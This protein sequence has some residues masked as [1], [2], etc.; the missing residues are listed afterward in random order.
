MTHYAIYRLDG[1]TPER[2]FTKVLVCPG[3]D[4]WEEALKTIRTFEQMRPGHVFVLESQ[5]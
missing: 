3:F 4:C 5:I 2:D 1:W